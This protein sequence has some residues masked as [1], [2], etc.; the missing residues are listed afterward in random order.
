MESSQTINDPLGCPGVGSSLGVRAWGHPQQSPKRSINLFTVNKLKLKPLPC[1]WLNTRALG[2]D[3]TQLW[4]SI[5]SF[6]NIQVQGQKSPSLLLGFCVCLNSKS[7]GGL[8][9][10][11]GPRPLPLPPQV[12][13]PQLYRPAFSH[14]DIY[15]YMYVYITYTASIYINVHSFLE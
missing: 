10:L 7:P 1:S 6:T 14:I 2:S 15:I 11:R 5:N 3:G 8:P 12:P 9:W 4:V 13:E